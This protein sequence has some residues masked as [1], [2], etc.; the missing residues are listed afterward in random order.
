MR[1]DAD[2]VV[3][4]G[5]LA[6]RWLKGRL[7]GRT[8]YF[9]VLRTGR[10]QTEQAWSAEGGKAFEAALTQCTAFRAVRGRK[11][12]GGFSE[13]RFNPDALE[14]FPLSDRVSDVVLPEDSQL[15]FEN[16]AALSG[17]ASPSPQ[18]DED[19]I[20]NLLRDAS[21]DGIRLSR[22]IISRTFGSVFLKSSRGF[23]GAYAKRGMHI[24]LGGA[25]ASAGQTWNSHDSM[26]ESISYDRLRSRVGR[27]LRRLPARTHW[28]DQ[29]DGVWWS[30]GA[31]G[32]FLEEI[33]S[34]WNAGS[35]SVLSVPS[36]PESGALLF[37]EKVRIDDDPFDGALFGW[38]PFDAQGHR[39]RLTPLI[40]EGRQIS[41]LTNRRLARENGLRNSANAYRTPTSGLF[42][43]PSNTLMAPGRDCIEEIAGG[44]RNVA[45]VV[46]LNPM[47]AS[48]NRGVVLARLASVLY[49]RGSLVARL[50]DRV[51]EVSVSDLF[52]AESVLSVD[53]GLHRPHHCISC[54]EVLTRPPNSIVRARQSLK[55]NRT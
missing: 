20:H 28:P 8:K 30:A 53:R 31:V 3:T 1:H 18:D 14:S 34:W 52:G 6:F 27:C 36:N 16:R 26:E 38:R 42:V 17:T 45:H 24:G 47:N 35:R 29:V 15:G 43:A 44:V 51:T 37:S 54:P 55:G 41:C 46:A 4:G 25:G 32:E 23:Q 11:V 10:F 12:W 48:P 49:Q 22:V 39:S 9:D 7:G 19:S 40:G 5:N 21:A 2:E 13:G 33:A 50:P